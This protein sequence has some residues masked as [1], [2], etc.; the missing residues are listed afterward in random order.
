MKKKQDPIQVKST[1]ARNFNASNDDSYAGDFYSAVTSVGFWKKEEPLRWTSKIL[2][3]Y[4]LEL[5]IDPADGDEIAI[6]L[7]PCELKNSPKVKGPTLV[8]F[9]LADSHKSFNAHNLIRGEEIKDG[10][11]FIDWR[12]IMQEEFFCNVLV[13]HYTLAE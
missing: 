2:F 13:I 3:H 11:L 12:R 6:S 5:H 10:I 8:Q 7:A 9:A 4:G 1:T